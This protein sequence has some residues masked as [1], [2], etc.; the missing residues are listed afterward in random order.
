[1]AHTFKYILKK[2]TVDEYLTSSNTWSTN[3]LDAK[4]FTKDDLDLLPTGSY[5]QLFIWDVT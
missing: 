3:I 4:S 5:I 2:L 1:M